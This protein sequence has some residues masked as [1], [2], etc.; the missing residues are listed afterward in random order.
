M[1]R[2]F[3]ERFG[4]FPYL[5]LL[6]FVILLR[7]IGDWAVIGA[8][9]VVTRDLPAGVAAAGVPA[10]VV[11]GRTTSRTGFGWDVV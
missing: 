5:F 8:G 1:V 10:R 4:R 3:L 6:D 2:S 7:T 9:S 11:R